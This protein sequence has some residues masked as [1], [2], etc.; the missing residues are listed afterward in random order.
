MVADANG[1]RLYHLCSLYEPP[2]F[3]KDASSTEIAGDD[4]LPA[5]AYADPVGRHY[6]IHTKAATWVSAAYY[7]DD[8]V[9][10]PSVETRL[11]Q[12]ARLHGIAA[13]VEE[14]RHRVK[15][16]MAT[17]QV[18]PEDCALTYED[19]DGTVRGVYPLRNALEVQKAAEYLQQH[20]A[21]LPYDDR[22]TFARSVLQRASEHGAPLNTE[23]QTFLAKQ[24]GHGH[25]AAADVADFLLGRAALLASRQLDGAHELHKLATV[26]LQQPEL[27][28]TPGALTKLASIIHQMD[29]ECG[30]KDLEGLEPPEDVF[31]AVT[32][33]VAS[34]LLETH[35][36]SA[37]GKVYRTA[38]FAKLSLSEIQES[39]G[40]DIAEAVST[41]GIQVAPEK[42]AAVLPTL[43]RPETELMEVILS[44]AGIRPVARESGDGDWTR[45]GFLEE[46]ARKYRPS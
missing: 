17:P 30:L 25:C 4:Q 27:C 28:R 8:D 12:A 14:L 32:P 42:L 16:A 19:A 34:E 43:P 18:Q 15:E 41:G 23:Q 5:R 24:A 9:P 31:F 35:C 21:V 38:D 46:E 10:V 6:P 3:V 29:S 2:E 13:D 26:C 37:T 44:G 39:F 1:Q 45:R 7:F 40:D 33:K 36:Q 11:L 20:A 22:L